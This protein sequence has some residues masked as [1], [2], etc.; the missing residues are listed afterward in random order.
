MVDLLRINKNNNMFFYGISSQ[1]HMISLLKPSSSFSPVNTTV[2]QSQH[3]PLAEIWRTV[4]LI[5]ILMDAWL[6]FDDEKGGISPNSLRT[7]E[8]V[9]I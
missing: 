3:N 1:G 6:T 5:Y 9:C 2:I 4:H 7:S 8:Q